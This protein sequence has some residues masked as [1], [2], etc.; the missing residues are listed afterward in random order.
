MNADASTEP[1]RRTC[2]YSRHVALGA[3][4]APFGGFAMPIQYAGILDE[5]AAARRDTVIFDTCHMGE[6]R[7]TGNQAVADLERLITCD[8]ATLA[9][10]QC[11][12]GLLCNP[13]GGVLDDLLV[14]RLGEQAFLI[15]VN[16]GT[17]DAD[18]AWLQ[19]HA[20]PSTTLVNASAETGKV[21]IQG[22]GSLALLEPMME[23]PLRDLRYYR[24]HQNH[25][26]GVPVLVSRTGYTG[27]RGFEVY[28][29][30]AT[31]GTLWDAC[32]AR[33]ALPAG[34]GARDTLRLEMGM[35]L[36]GHELS[37]ER[38]AAASGFTTPLSTRKPYIGAEAV[39]DP[40]QRRETLIGVCF[41]DR[42][43]A[44]AGDRV[45]AADGSPI[46][47]VTSGSFAPSL[48]HAIALAYVQ[49]AHA[50]PGA[51]AHV[52]T[53]RQRLDG[54]FHRPPFYTAGTARR[55]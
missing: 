44:R 48:G 43:A 18:F 6:F 11:R 3:R 42:R 19:A 16:A 54:T 51:P 1:V 37:A 8:V 49:T 9:V 38:N 47:T 31:T 12:Y 46:G 28:A 41:P 53:A 27:E 45:V 26:A 21:D 23:Q 4:M 10:G 15:V 55:A 24:F 36:Y 29:D 20:S 39:R 32:L 33:G 17:Q 14:Y 35:P 30:E 40:E 50:R 5:H 13:A 34:L 52:Q 7:V 22:P 25:F 2:L